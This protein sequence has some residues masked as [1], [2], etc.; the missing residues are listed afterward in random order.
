MEN[1]ITVGAL[2]STL[3][4][5]T[6][7]SKRLCED[8]LREFFKLAAETLET[9]DALR[10]KGFGAFKVVEVDSRTGVNVNTGERQEIPAYR[11]VVFTPS[12]ELASVINAPFEEF[13]SV[14]LEDEF[15]EEMLEWDDSGEE[16]V[17]ESYP[18]AE[19]M[20]DE[21]EAEE[22]REEESGDS[23]NFKD[24]EIEGEEIKDDEISDEDKVSNYR[25]ED[26]SDEEDED[27]IIT[28]EAYNEIEKEEKEEKLA[29]PVNDEKPQDLED[30]PPVEEDSSP[31]NEE[32]EK[33]AET[34]RQERFDVPVYEE[35]EQPAVKSRYGVGFLTGALSTFALCAVI[36]MLGCF[37]NWW[38][39]N[40]GKA[41]DM[42]EEIRE[43]QAEPA[44]SP[45]LDVTDEQT[46][47][48]PQAEPVYDT[49][50][51]TRY[52]TTIARDHYGN[53][54]FWPYI[55]LENESILGHPD[56]ITPGTKVVVPDLSKY[57]VDPKNKE[58]IAAAKNKS[59]EIYSRFK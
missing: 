19:D 5:T 46:E 41:A 57:G 14:E 15:P 52:L 17:E 37:F 54:N 4:Q 26:G 3:S 29:A 36:F 12:K 10:I 44:E 38:P 28:Y 2:A 53:F 51:T 13:D 30:T 43:E 23:E 45:I 58:D 22:E 25:L 34:T 7:K 24:D 48:Q 42:A 32:E 56:R 16:V 8:F 18:D 31:E 11:K 20:S 40:F 59:L 1:K 27:D 33:P 6:G 39:V 9:G 50:S 47:E 35:Y 49:V 55:Y 21:K